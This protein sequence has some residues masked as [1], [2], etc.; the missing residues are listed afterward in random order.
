M[1]RVDRTKYQAEL[2]AVAK[3]LGLPAHGNVEGLII[4][5]CSGQL[6]AWV[7]L[8]GQPNSLTELLDLF[9]ASL[10]MKF[11]E[12][13]DDA[14]LKALLAEVP[15]GKEP[16]MASL[17]T[18][19]DDATDAVM[20]RRSKYEPWERRFLAVVNC[21]GRHSKRVFFTKWHELVHCIINGQQLRLAFRKTRVDR[22]EPAE[23]LVDRIAAEL[24]FYP[25][26]FRPVVER[27]L[28]TSG[29]LTF[30]GVDRIRREVAPEASLQS[31]VIASMRYTEKPVWFIICAMGY[32][33][34]LER[35]LLNGQRILIPLPAPELRIQESGCSPAGSNL[36][37]MVHWNMRIPDSS[38]ISRVFKEN[39]SVPVRGHEKL[40]EW[41]I[42]SSGPIG[43]GDLEVEA[44]RTDDQVWALIHL[45]A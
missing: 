33:R 17:A 21:R 31:T 14:D 3:K 4:N 38:I 26:I 1:P 9:G 45:E 5:H 20:I 7:G 39:S 29:K 25:D 18:E 19:L 11:V 30:E 12:I 23:V 40:E 42:S 15:P 22:A 13:H 43:Y 27:E 16:I 10:N 41:Q 36:G 6:A 34:D 44:F 2:A 28:S 35:K 37:I 32:K 24:A 8:H